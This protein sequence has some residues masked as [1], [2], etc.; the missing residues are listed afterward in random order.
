[1]AVFH[2]DL[3]DQPAA[4]VVQVPDAQTFAILPG[5]SHTWRSLLK[6]LVQYNPQAGHPL[7][8]LVYAARELAIPHETRDGEGSR[9]VLIRRVT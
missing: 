1:M 7:L 3:P 6:Y 9:A 5:G 2:V 8:A 4:V